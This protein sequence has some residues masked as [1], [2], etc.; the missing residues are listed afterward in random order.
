[1]VWGCAWHH[2]HAAGPQGCL[3]TLSHAEHCHHADA[4]P[5]SDPDSAP[6][7]NDRDECDE[8]NCSFV[9]AKSSGTTSQAAQ[10]HVLA[11]ACDEPDVLTVSRLAAADPASFAAHPPPPLRLHLAKRVLLL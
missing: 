9:A 10:D 11:V 4:A 1:V 8:G 5:C 3:A 6:A 2:A 7:D